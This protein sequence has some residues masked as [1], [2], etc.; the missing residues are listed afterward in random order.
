MITLRRML[1]CGALAAALAVALVALMPLERL[2]GGDRPRVPTDELSVEMYSTSSCTYCRAARVYFRRNG[3]PFVEH[4]I[5]QSAEARERF[6]RLNGVGVP[7]I[8]VN[9]R[10]MEGFD[11]RRFER[12]RRKG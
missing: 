9:G 11:A 5:E 7:L 6:A 3:L 12:L 8:F 10:R 1:V 4:D 2:V